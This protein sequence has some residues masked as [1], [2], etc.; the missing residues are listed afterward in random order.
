MSIPSDPIPEAV[1]SNIVC[2]FSIRDVRISI[3]ALVKKIDA[4][5]YNSV[6]FA[7]ATLRLK[8]PRCAALIFSSGSIVC[9]G[10]RTQIEALNAAWRYSRFLQKYVGIEGV[11]SSFDIKNVV[12]SA[13]CLYQ[14]FNER[15]HVALPEFS[16]YNPEN[17][18]GLIYRDDT[19]YGN[20]TFLVFVS[21]KVVITGARTQ[22]ESVEK[23]N[24]FYSNLV[25]HY[26]DVHGEL[27]GMDSS[28]Y[29]HFISANRKRDQEDE[30]EDEALLYAMFGLGELDGDEDFA[31]ILI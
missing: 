9:P 1:I 3:D 29:K 21:G 5:A 27:G 2:G 12:S 15:I 8:N 31:S 10:T 14:I 17:F 16:K 22:E 7:A 28:E 30:E 26:L 19:Q 4:C 11:F 23:W 20:V 13:I 24:H 6:K 25:V 18:P